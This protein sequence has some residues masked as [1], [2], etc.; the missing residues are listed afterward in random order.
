MSKEIIEVNETEK[1]ENV[2]K[3]NECTSG[4][5]WQEKNMSMK[6]TRRKMRETVEGNNRRAEEKSRRKGRERL[7]VW[8]KIRM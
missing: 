7:Q 3:K 6:E 8:E 2:R 1:R 4:G 5:S